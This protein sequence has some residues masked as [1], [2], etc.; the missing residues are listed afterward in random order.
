MPG[1]AAF[2]GIFFP[3]LIY[4]LFNRHSPGTLKGWA[5]PIATDTAFMLGIL[6]FFS[7]V[8]SPKLRAFII[9]FSLI[10][11]ALALIILAIFYS[12]SASFL[13]VVATCLLTGALC[14][15]NWRQVTHSIYY[16]VIGVFLWIAMVKAGIHGTLAGVV[17]ALSLPVTT[18]QQVNPFFHELESLLRPIVYF[19]ILPLFSFINSGISFTDFRMDI[20]LSPLSLGIILGLFL[21]KQL[22]IFLCSYLA[23]KLRYCSL[24]ANVTWPTYYA[25]AILGGIGFTLSLFIGDLSF[26]AVD[27]NYAMRLSVV[28]GSLLSALMGI[29]L[30]LY[31][32]NKP[33]K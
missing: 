32:K 16:L 15:L 17:V 1:A 21:G 6:S 14:L 12:K 3:A 27:K 28:I 19:F 5:I 25:V 9:G 8:V 4:Y 10:D 18:G 13:A 22:G 26:E 23:V 29:A 33:L 31:I 2:G 30:L 7:S 11:D 24:P 20:L